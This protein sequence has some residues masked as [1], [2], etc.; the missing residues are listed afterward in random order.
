MGDK[1]RADGAGR[2][3]LAARPRHERRGRL[4]QVRAL[5]GEVGFPLL[6]KAAAGGGVAACAS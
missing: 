2:G 4:E 3:R 1:V 5:A 6:L